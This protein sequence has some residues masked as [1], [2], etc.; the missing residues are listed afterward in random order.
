MPVGQAKVLAQPLV[1]SV[2]SFIL[3]VGGFN[4]LRLKPYT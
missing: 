2:L 4:L 3:Q 1:G